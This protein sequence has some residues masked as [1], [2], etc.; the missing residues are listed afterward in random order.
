MPSFRRGIWHTSDDHKFTVAELKPQQEEQVEVNSCFVL[1]KGFIGNIVGLE[2]TNYVTFAYVLSQA[3]KKSY[4][5]TGNYK[6]AFL[7]DNLSAH[8][9]AVS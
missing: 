2:P 5:M 7:L 8:K 4:E 9:K 6:I 3:I 1:G